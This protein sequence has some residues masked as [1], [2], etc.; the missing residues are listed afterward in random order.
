MMT[1][2]SEHTKS[3]CSKDDAEYSFWITKG[4]QNLYLIYIFDALVYSWLQPK[5]I[6]RQDNVVEKL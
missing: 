6:A 2:T 5:I 1:R 3:C 4:K